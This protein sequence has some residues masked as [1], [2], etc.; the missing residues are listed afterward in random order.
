MR[1]SSSISAGSNRAPRW[2]SGMQDQH[3]VHRRTRKHAL[4]MRVHLGKAR[5]VDTV[6]F[7]PAGDGEQVGIAHAVRLAHHPGP[8]E[9]VGLDQREAVAHVLRHLLFH[10]LDRRRVVGP[11]RP[12]PLVRVRHVHRRAQVAVDGL[13]ARELPR[14]ARRQLRRGENLRQIGEDGR[15]LG[16]HAMV[17]DQ[18]RHAALGI[19]PQVI[20][21]PLVVA[22]EIH[23]YRF[24]GGAGLFENDLGGERAGIGGVIKFEHVSGLSWMKSGWTIR[25]GYWHP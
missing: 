4:K 10:R 6:A 21:A 2:P 8:G 9:H 5:D 7:E 20:G 25:C 3:L 17:G 1:C 18:G 19:D 16:Q 14:V 11:A 23:A 12:A 13:R 24:V 15:G 22:R